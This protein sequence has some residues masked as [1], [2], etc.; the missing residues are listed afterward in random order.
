[1][2]GIERSGGNGSIGGIM[3]LS[4]QVRYSLAVVCILAA[5]VGF[6]GVAHLHGFRSLISASTYATSETL[7]D[8]LFEQE[9]RQGEALAALLARLLADPLFGGKPEA[10]QHLAESAAAGRGGVYVAVHDD[11]GRPIAFV[12]PKDAGAGREGARKGGDT[13]PPGPPPG[14]VGR[15]LTEGKTQILMDESLLHV[16]APIRWSGRTIGAVTVG[17]SRRDTKAELASFEGYMDAVAETSIQYFLILYIGIA[18][19]IVVI[20]FGIGIVMV[21]DMARPIHALG[22]YMRRIGTGNYDEPPPFER[23]DEL[24]DLARELG[25]MAQ[26]LKKVA[27]VSR[28]ATLGEMSVGVAHELNQP[29]NTIRMAAENALLSRQSSA[30]DPEF[31]D[32]KLRLISGQAA[33]MGDLIQRMCIVGRGEGARELIDARESVRDAVSLLANQCEDDGIDLRV[34]L[35]EDDALVLGQR[36]ELAQVVINLI[37]NARDAILESRKEAQGEA[38]A[39]PGVID[40]GLEVSPTAVVIRVADNG[41]GIASEAIGRIFDPFF[42]TKEVTKGTGLGLSISFGIA[43]A[44]GGTLRAENIGDGATFTLDLPRASRKETARAE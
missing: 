44:M 20:G 9:K 27:Q 16:S 25:R 22:R 4:L 38:Q 1:M 23:T 19:M 34:H 8:A 37:G 11:G 31:V 32:G 15:A 14:Q 33:N 2:G 41:G 28:L 10:V 29:L 26:N 35:P 12:R 18:L 30:D 36:N 7:S 39:P 43:N 40:V 21:R 6:M 24:G 42:T 5:V 3:K 13:A 17:I